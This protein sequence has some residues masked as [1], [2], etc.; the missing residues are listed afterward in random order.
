MTQSLGLISSPLTITALTKNI[1]LNQDHGKEIH[2]VSAVLCVL[3]EAQTRNFS[4][5]FYVVTILIN[6]ISTEYLISIDYKSCT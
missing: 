5:L 2:S 4:Q 1:N 3:I 6:H